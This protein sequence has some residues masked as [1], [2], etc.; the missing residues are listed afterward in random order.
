MEITKI[1]VVN[2]GGEYEV[3]VE[4]NNTELL[5]QKYQHDIKVNKDTFGWKNYGD[6]GLYRFSVIDENGKQWSS[7]NYTMKMLTGID[8]YPVCVRNNN[9]TVA[10]MECNKL[11]S[12]LLPLGYTII[13]DMY[14]DRKVV[15]F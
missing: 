8:T 15:K 6:T 4:V 1:E 14:G 3:Y 11:L 2:I 9:K 10:Y 12:Y 7:N 13:A 5:N